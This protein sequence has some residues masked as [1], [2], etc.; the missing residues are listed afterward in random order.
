M[1]ADV[2]GNLAITIG[3]N[4]FFDEEYILLL[5]LAV[6]LIRWIKKIESSE[7]VDFYYES[8]D[9][10]DK[11]ILAFILNHNN[12]WR[13]YSVWEIFTDRSEISLEELLQT[14]NQFISELT[15]YIKTNFGLD[16]FSLGSI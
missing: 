15:T 9:Y 13:L 12:S 3:E 4:T 16:L 5:E 10:E 8:M 6:A 2:E 11:P 14:I 1:L 7:M